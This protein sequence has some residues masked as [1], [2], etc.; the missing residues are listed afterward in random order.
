MSRVEDEEE[1]D[2]CFY[3]S[4]DRL[5]S[6]SCSCSTSNSD[7]D[8][9]SNSNSPNY[10]SNQ[11]FPIP[12]FPV[13]MSKFDIWISEPSSVLA[14]RT[15]L[16]HAMGLSGD[17][18]LSRGKPASAADLRE[19]DNGEFERS[20]SSNHLS[21]DSSVF[22]QSHD[23]CNKSSF[24]SSSILSIHPVAPENGSLVNE[25]YLLEKAD[26]MHYVPSWM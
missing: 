10:D 4:H 17:P 7:D 24:C 5:V 26:C 19:M 15:R 18:S 9:N 3:E 1:E 16:L 23:R 6:S 2:E 22:A 25:W 8:N 13:A 21:R 14:R 20:A 12:K 11:P